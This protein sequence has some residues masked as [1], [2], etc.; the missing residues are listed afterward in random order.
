MCIY[1][2]MGR[3]SEKTSAGDSGSGKD[4]GC[5]CF[6]IRRAARAVTRLYD[7]TIR[8]TGL[9]SSQVMLLMGVRAMGPVSV[10][11]LAEEA[12]LDRTTLTRNLRP[13]E[14]EGLVRIEQGVDRRERV[15][16]LTAKGDSRLKVA[17]PVMRKA[18]QKVEELVGGNCVSRVIEDL[19]RLVGATRTRA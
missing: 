2:D 1:T 6:N 7:D 15:V 10:G 9:R 18:Q 19:G 14:R 13:L 17:M 8:S 5:A 11:N 16:S 4:S 12:V 3:G